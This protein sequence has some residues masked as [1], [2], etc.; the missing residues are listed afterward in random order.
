LLLRNWRLWCS[1]TFN[2]DI[3]KLSLKF[4]EKFQ[5]VVFFRNAYLVFIWHFQLFWI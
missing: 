5:I 2:V 4:F 3:K 1:N